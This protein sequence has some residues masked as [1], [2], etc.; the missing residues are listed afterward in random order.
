MGWARVLSV[1][2]PMVARMSPKAI[3]PQ[4]LLKE[5]NPQQREVATTFGV[6]VVV[7][8]GAGTGKTRTIT[9]RI[10]YGVATG[11]QDARATLA[12]TFTQRAAGE[13]RS[14]LH[15]L[16]VPNV[17]ARTFHSAA[18]RQLRYFWA[19]AHSQELPEVSSHNLGIVAE[20][21]RAAGLSGDI[22][23]LRDLA[24]EIS[25]AKVSNVTIEGYANLAASKGRTVAGVDV[26]QVANVM[27]GY[28]RIK[29]RRGVI[30]LDD[31]LLCTVALLHEQPAIAAQVRQTYRHFTVDEFQDV[32]PLQ[33]SLLRLWVD[34]RDDICVVGD[35]DQSIHAFAGAQRGYLLQQARPN[36]G[37]KVLHL[38]QNY[39][40][41]PQIVALANALMARRRGRQPLRATK[42][43]GPVVQATAAADDVSEAREVANW[44][45]G[46]HDQGLGWDQ[47]AVLFRIHAQS[48]P[49][50]AALSEANVA[51][52]VRDSEGFYAR[53]EIRR[54]MQELTKAAGEPGEPVQLVQQILTPLGWSAQAPQGAGQLRARWESLNALVDLAADLVAKGASNL[55]SVVDQMSKRAA[56]Q[57]AP[58]A[59][60][61]TLSTMHSAKGLEWQAV[62][63]VGVREGMM[64]FSLATRADQIAEEHRLLYVAVTRAQ[65]WL[66]ISWANSSSGGR[67]QRPSRFFAA[68]AGHV[69]TEGVLPAPKPARRASKH[70]KLCTVCGR[71]LTIGSELKLGHHQGCEVLFDEE[72]FE[73]LR[74]WRLRRA[75]AD[76]VPAFVVFTDATL[77]AIVERRPGSH[78]DLLQV[79]GVGMVKSERY[80]ADLLT[81]IAGTE[82]G[83]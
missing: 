48:P 21:A 11:Q 3:D 76:S 24:A 26:E 25:W 47:M 72:L 36:S 74:R 65:Q 81:I 8:A 61:V 10:A 4:A 30:D 78:Q 69:E 55:S 79:P 82:P 67:T 31:I 73:T 50:E 42:A 32:S 63:V 49:F 14:R 2:G 56:V 23:Q 38:D 28:E 20:A 16:G 46:L 12:V 6:P 43:N 7:L 75:E 19:R 22:A 70:P 1:A 33:N 83:G 27:A 54:A 29:R 51:Y 13:M 59:N 66:R 77:R 57:H 53:P 37:V 52:F 80:G 71:M 9:H 35:P 45:V 62:A 34:G 17:Q 41:S 5:L 15:D 58:T 40:S 60:G 64:P 39:R 44:L 18:L 68:L